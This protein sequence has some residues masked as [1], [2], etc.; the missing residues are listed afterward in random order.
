MKINFLSKCVSLFLFGITSSTLF[1]QDTSTSQKKAIKQTTLFVKSNTYKSIVFTSEV[2]K[3]NKIASI[4]NFIDY[5]LRQG[6]SKDKLKQY[7]ERIEMVKKS[8]IVN[9]IDSK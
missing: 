9:P 2:Q 7:Y 3:Q 4:Q 6:E 5:K 1:A 8:K